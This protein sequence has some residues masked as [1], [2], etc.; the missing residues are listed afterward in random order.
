M[1]GPKRY[2]RSC[3]PGMVMRCGAEKPPRIA[4]L[5]SKAEKKVPRRGLAFGELEALAGSLLTVL[6]SLMSARIAREKTE[7]LE[8]TSQFDI[9]L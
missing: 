3:G 4:G 8:L 1:R 7:L 6:L 5:E 2:L 9:E